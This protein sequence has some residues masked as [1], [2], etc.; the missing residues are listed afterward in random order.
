M[1]WNWN[2]WKEMERQKQETQDPP[3]LF[4]LLIALPW[5]FSFNVEGFGVKN[6]T[7]PQSPNTEQFISL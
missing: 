5:F 4:L 7:F 3:G 6:K 1:Q 2:T